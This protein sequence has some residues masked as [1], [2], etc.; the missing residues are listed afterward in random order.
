MSTYTLDDL[1]YWEERIREKVEEFGLSCF[2]QEFELCD[3]RQMIGYMSY[4]G[5][6]SHYPHWSY[7]KSYEKQE[8]LYRYG[9]T[10]LP[11]E[12]VINS[13]PSLAYLM[14]D[15]SL[16]LQIL[17]MAHVYGHNDFFKNNFTF[18]HTNPSRVLER[19]NAA[20]DRIRRYKED[21]SVGSERVER[22]LDGAHALA[23]QCRRN[24]AIPKLSQEEQRRR[25]LEEFHENKEGTLPDLEK[26]PLSPE[27]DIL[28]FIR[29]HGHR[30]AE[31]EKDVLTIVHEEMQYFIPQMET[32][33][34][35][36]GWAC[37]WHR[38][39]LQSLRLPQELHLEFLVR[40]NQVVRP[41]Y[42]GVNPY[43]VG[44]AIWDDIYR[45]YK[46]S[47]RNEIEKYGTPEKSASEKL[48]EVREV[49]R[50]VSFLRRFLTEE[51]M[52]KLDMFRYRPFGKEVIIT[53]VSDEYGWR[54]V[55]D[56]LLKDI[57]VETIPIIKIED[58]NYTGPRVLFLKHYHDG[59]DLDVT[60]AEKTLR[61]VQK[62]W[63]ARVML[64]TVRD[65]KVVNYRLTNKGNLKITTK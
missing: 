49:D 51:L 58:A 60:Y 59:R 64:E 39:I 5:M 36:E 28:L 18:M 25:M 37:F 31:W 8:T 50:D 55:K 4:H 34:I 13:D 1:A 61:H 41:H 16:C 38:R 9:V 14:K 3:H 17:T 6:P 11:Y 54:A 46:S 24:F 26:L 30:L 42:G 43:H 12:M 45:R 40:H 10:G 48:F 19:V 57:G 33:I 65:E 7:G 22:V 56:R 62:L 27:E 53:D 20:A 21:P 23:L 35:N 29:D 44:L 52:R 32:K 2:S 63:R 15:N 47:T